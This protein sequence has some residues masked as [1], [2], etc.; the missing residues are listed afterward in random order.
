[1][2]GCR[3]GSS[4]SESNCMR[5][6]LLCVPVLAAAAS[7]G[8]GGDEVPVYGPGP[9]RRDPVAPGPLGGKI[10]TSNSFDD[11]LSVVDPDAPGAVGRIPVGFSPVELEGPHHLSVDPAGRF[12][13]VNLSLAVKG[14][15][16]GP[17]GVHGSG[18]LPG[19]VLK[20]NTSDGREV[21]RA[22]VDSNPGD[23]TLAPDGKTLYVS[24][25]DVVAWSRAAA[26]GDLHMG[27]SFLIALDTER[28]VVTARVALCP[29]AH[30]VRLSADG[31]TLFATCG[32]DQIAV[33]DVRDPTLPVRRVQLPGTTEGANC[34]RCPYALSVAPDGTVW[35]SSL[36]PSGGT[37]GRG[38]IDVYDPAQDG[39]GG[40]DAKR[41]LNLRGSPV[42]A[43]FAPGAG[44]F[45]VL[46]P[47]QGK[48]GDFVQVLDPARPGEPPKIQATIALSPQDCLLA[49]MLLVS[50]DGTRAHLVCEGDHTGPGSVVWLDLRT[51]STLGSR[52]VGVFPDG[53]ALVPNLVKR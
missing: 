10:L 25:Y 27:D 51:Q 8:C 11:T 17:H 20:L 45:R 23:S 41:T 9:F 24:H 37:N 19:Y 1:M 22:R 40:F 16:S 50:A 36:G 31:H 32:P 33:V 44:N 7:A 29:A 34:A 15:G 18:E 14:S 30:G 49:H 48:A 12:V 38:G 4:A 6:W 5:P 42:F 28:M 39:G 35:V 47:E 21:A 46:V 53:L 52:P 13:Y 2:K 3:T 26:A 43:A